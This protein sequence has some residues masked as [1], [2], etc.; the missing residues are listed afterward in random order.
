LRLTIE[1]F[2]ALSQAVGAK[3]V[4]VE[5][6]DNTTVGD[7]LEHLSVSHPSLGELLG[8][9]SVAVNMAYVGTADVLTDDDE[10]AL[11]PPVSGG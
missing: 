1:L 4:S 11:I 5:L 2:A 8:S 9:V 10:V 6:P 3:T 7:L